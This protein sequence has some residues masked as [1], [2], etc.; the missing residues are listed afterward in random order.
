MTTSTTIL[1][2]IFVQCTFGSWA[3]DPFHIVTLSPHFI[4]T[5]SHCWCCGVPVCLY[6]QQRAVFPQHHQHPAS[7][8]LKFTHTHTLKFTYGSGILM[9]GTAL[10]F[11]E[12]PAV[13]VW[14]I[15]WLNLGWCI[16][17]TRLWMMTNH[18][19][20]SYFIINS[21]IKEYKNNC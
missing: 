4:Q 12:P 1:S 19:T 2:S 21:G 8:S 5:K 6:G 20:F 18:D 16:M 10:Y 7:H 13:S 17:G 15:I 14:E 11:L 3:S 9:W